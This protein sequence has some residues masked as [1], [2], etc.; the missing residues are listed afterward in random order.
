MSSTPDNDC[1]SPGAMKSQ[2]AGEYVIKMNENS[3]PVK[4]E[5]PFFSLVS[6]G[7]IIELKHF[8]IVFVY[9]SGTLLQE[10]VVCTFLVS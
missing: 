6:F 9:S 4:W 7:Q 8:L 10:S 2:N 3:K 1:V 5:I